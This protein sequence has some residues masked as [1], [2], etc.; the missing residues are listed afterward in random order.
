MATENCALINM[1]M[2]PKHS[3]LFLGNQV[4]CTI[5]Q[6]GFILIQHSSGKKKGSG[7]NSGLFQLPVDR[8]KSKAVKTQKKGHPQ[9]NCS[10]LEVI[11]SRKTGRKFPL[12]DGL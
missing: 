10:E 5:T 6:D 2:R 8:G 4:P 7:T 11:R 9:R 12:S 3:K 1:N